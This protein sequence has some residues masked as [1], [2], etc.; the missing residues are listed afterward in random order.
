MEEGFG[1]NF[2]IWGRRKVGIEWLRMEHQKKGNFFDDDDDGA[3]GKEERWNS[4]S[5]VMEAE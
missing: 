3:V 4:G 1:G 2:E 5:R